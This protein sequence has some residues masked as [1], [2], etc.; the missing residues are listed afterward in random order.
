MRPLPRAVTVS[1]SCSARHAASS[2]LYGQ[3]AFFNTLDDSTASFL[4]SIAPGDFG[5]KVRIVS[6]MPD[7]FEPDIFY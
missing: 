5:A 2:A 4:Y 6:Y 3:P 7:L 1:C